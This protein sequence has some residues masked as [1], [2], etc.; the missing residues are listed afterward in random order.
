MH[1]IRTPWRLFATAMALAALAHNP[2]L[3]P[4]LAGRGVPVTLSG[5]T[6][7]GQL[8]IPRLGW[9]IASPFLELASR[10]ES[11]PIVFITAHKEESERPQL[12]ARGAIECL[13]KPF[14][15]SAL[16]DAVEKALRA[17]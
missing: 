6:H 14:S 8:S 16:L 1:E 13:F 11:V 17:S 2:A 15:E 7:H 5:H 10:R 12:L 3:W 9:S 4:A